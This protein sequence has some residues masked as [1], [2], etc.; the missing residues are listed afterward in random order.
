MVAGSSCPC[1]LLPTEFLLLHPGGAEDSEPAASRCLP[2]EEAAEPLGIMCGTRAD[3]HW[4]LVLFVRQ[5]LSDPVSALKHTTT[6]GRP[7]S[8]ACSCSF[9]VQRQDFK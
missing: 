9:N 8:R 1:C 2:V 3:V 6:R 7:H 4:L 5:T